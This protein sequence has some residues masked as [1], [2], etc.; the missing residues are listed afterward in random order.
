MHS[1]AATAGTRPSAILHRAGAAT[2]PQVRLYHPACS[3]YTALVIERKL[4]L[5]HSALLLYT[6]AACFLF[7]MSWRAATA[8][9][10]QKTA[11]ESAN[12]NPQKPES[13]KAAHPAQIALLETK[14][15]FEANGDNR[16]EVHALVKINSE[17]GVRQFAQLNFD[18]NRSFESVEIPIVHIIHSSGGT[19]D[20]LPSAVTDHPNP[21]VVNAPAYQDVRVKS[22]RILGLQ[23]GDTLEYRVI[24]TVSHHPL[25]PDFWVE[26]T[27]DPSGV[28]LR[29]TYELDLPTS[30]ENRPEVP[31]RS[32]N[33][34]VNPATPITSAQK[35]V[36]ADSPRMTYR[37]ERTAPPDNSEHQELRENTEPDVSYSNFGNWDHLSVRLAEELTPGAVPLVSIRNS[38]ESMRELQE[39]PIVSQAIQAKAL[40][41]TTSARTDH[42]KLEAIYDFVSRKITTVGIPLGSTGFAP[43]SADDVLSTGYASAEDKFVLF[44]ALTKSLKLHAN[45]AL[46]GYCDKNGVARPSV[47]SH[48]LIFVNDGQSKYWLDPSLEVAPFGIVSPVSQKCVF[49]LNRFFYV[50]NSTGHEWQPFNRELPFQALQKV[51]VNASLA[52]DGKLLAKVNYAMRGDNELVLRVA[53]HRTPKERWKE[54]AQLL[55]ITDGFRGQ[56]SSVNASD[57]YATKESFTVEYELDQPK[58][59]DWLKKT[60]RI[61]ALLPQLGLPDPP[62]KPASGRATAPINLGTPLEVETKMTLHLPPGIGASAPAG[63]SVERDYATYSSQYAVNGST[64][65]ATRRIKFVLTEVPA[66]RAA[67]YNAFLRAVQSDEAQD[68]TLEPPSNGPKTNSA[69]SNTAT[70]PKP[71][72]PKP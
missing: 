44:A 71:V 10:P 25:A 27:F 67:D 51:E 38:E 68:F 8:Q 1:D 32:L 64:L 4:S 69:A 45:A 22:V 72:A 33:F 14:V 24:R 26:H 47:F 36:E 49:E 66:S 29:E 63:T 70:P 57:P 37:W 55:S 6:A 19:V 7:T 34:Y 59:V 40:E 41:L 5:K 15:R 30:Q 17:L 20:I 3:F 62:A 58:F 35:S 60:I 65:T 13:E 23:P 46:T 53:F 43:R 12:K 2:V 28:V 39:K 54:V 56:V 11:A 21:A 18:F 42:E 9:E 50:M 52:D 31:R 61:P 48:L 16:K